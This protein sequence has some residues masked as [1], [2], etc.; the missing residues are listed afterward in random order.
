MAADVIEC[1]KSKEIMTSKFAMND[2]AA[3][4]MTSGANQRAPAAY[5]TGAFGLDSD[6]NMAILVALV[7]EIR[8][9]LVANGMMK[10]AA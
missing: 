1:L 2:V 9:T 7:V 3:Q 8:A 4:S 10:G 6:A 5:N